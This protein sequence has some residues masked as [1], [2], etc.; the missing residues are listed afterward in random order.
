[1]IENCE[2][3]IE[4]FFLVYMTIQEALAKAGST[5]QLSPLDSGILLSLTL[6]RPKEYILAHPEKKLTKL[7]EKKFINFAKRR[8]VGE[9]VAYIVGKKEFFGL[10]FI[11]NKNVLIPRPETELLVEHAIEK[12]KQYPVETQNFASLR[13]DDKLT[14]IDVGTGSGNLIVSI[15]KNIPKKIK[16]KIIFYAIDI[17]K[18]SLEVAKNNAK[19]NKAVKEIKFIQSDML[20]YFLKKIKFPPK[21]DQPLAENFE[22]I[23]IIANLP[24]VSPLLYQKYN[25]NLKFEPKTALLSRNN[26]LAHYIK[27]LNQIKSLITSARGGSA[28]GGDHYSL[29]L[30]ISPEQKPEIGHIIEKYLPKAKTSFR[31]DLAGKW[32]M[33]MLSF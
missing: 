6:N 8:S 31:K 27:L 25:H 29:I 9:P 2:L 13:V 18:E 12:I 20:E 1:L 30:E 4:N 26:G 19:K 33:A 11:V 14:V 24:Y 17:S 32:R 28:S 16:K 10:D 22:N 21:A 15:A 7:Q 5:H 23:L 3:K